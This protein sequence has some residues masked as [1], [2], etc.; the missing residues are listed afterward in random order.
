MNIRTFTFLVVF[1]LVITGATSLLI[2]QQWIIAKKQTEAD[3]KLRIDKNKM[4]NKLSDLYNNLNTKNDYD[5]FINEANACDNKTELLNK[6]KLKYAIILFKEA[7][8]I[9]TRARMLQ[10]SLNNQ[11]VKYPD[12]TFRDNKDSEKLHPLVESL[13]ADAIQK[14]ELV[15]VFCDELKEMD[16]NNLNYSYYYI[17]GE[18]YHRYMQMFSDQQT[19]MEYFNQAITSYKGALNCREGDTSTTVNIELLLK[20]QESLAE[21][22]GK[23]QPQPNKTTRILNQVG[24]SN[25]KGN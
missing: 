6:A 13:V 16:N 18:I 14:Y 5:N 7:D 20:Q 10:A 23:N 17:K 22:M 15:K 25:L 8:L 4:L 12:S 19:F 9:T 24:I 21:Q 3:E 1:A 11:L 2:H